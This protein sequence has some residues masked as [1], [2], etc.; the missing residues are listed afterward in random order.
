MC[1]IIARV[2]RAPASVAVTG[3]GRI[4]RRA[5]AAAGGSARW[6]RARRPAWQAR[7]G[8]CPQ[9]P[10][11]ANVALGLLVVFEQASST[12]ARRA[13]AVRRVAVD[14]CR[15]G[16]PPVSH[17]EPLR[18]RVEVVQYK[19]ENRTISGMLSAIAIKYELVN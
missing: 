5:G 9:A 14:K 2:R 12:R 16:R 18:L 8:A 13:R 4:G 11:R 1:S 10:A 15:V 3:N 19:Y 6:A 17:V 7:S